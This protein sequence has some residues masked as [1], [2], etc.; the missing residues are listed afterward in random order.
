[1]LLTVTTEQRP[2]VPDEERVEGSEIGQGLW[3]VVVRYG[4]F[5]E[6]NVPAALGVALRRLKLPISV[7]DITYYIGRET[8]LATNEGA[9][10]R[11][12]ELSFATLSRNSL[13][14]TAYFKIP[15]NRVVELGMQIDL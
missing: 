15:P 11:F 5:E 3:R 7:D 12:A 2:R 4:F 6:P 10:G 13:S 1:V 9:M 14:A 8:L